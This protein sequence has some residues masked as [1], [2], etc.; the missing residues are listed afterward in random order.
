MWS[1][2]G[3][4][5]EIQV[6]TVHVHEQPPWLKTHA[7]AMSL[8]CVLPLLSGTLNHLLP[9][10]SSNISGISDDRRSP[11]WVSMHRA[12]LCLMLLGSCVV[13]VRGA[14]GSSSSYAMGKRTY[15]SA[16]GGPS[17]IHADTSPVSLF[18][19]LNS[20]AIQFFGVRQCEW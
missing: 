17:S 1:A 14:P 5:P 18:T 15:D 11:T 6:R 12:V 4:S 16:M 13:N 20:D 7:A 19:M 3:A 8:R 2:A 9:F 10:A